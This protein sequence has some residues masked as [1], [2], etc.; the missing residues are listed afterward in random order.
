MNIVTS[1]SMLDTISFISEAPVG[2]SSLTVI[3]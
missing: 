1:V 3:V 2:D